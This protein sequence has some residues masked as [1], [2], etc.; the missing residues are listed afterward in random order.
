MK[1]RDEY[2]KR[3]REKH[4]DEINKRKKEHY[5]NNKDKALAYRK[6]N[7]EDISESGAK[8]YKKNRKIILKKG[9]IYREKNKEII[10]KNKS[11]YGK[12]NRCEIR[13][14][15]IEYYKIPENKKKKDKSRKLYLKNPKNRL[16]ANLRIM[17][18]QSLK[19]YT[20]TGKIKS[21]R[22]YDINYRD[23]I[24]HLKPFPKDISKYHV[25]HIRPLCSFNFMNK[26]GSQNLEEIKK[27]FA[28]EN[29]QWLT[30]FENMSKGGKW[31][32]STTT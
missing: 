29:L 12:K 28:P 6:K 19:I 27:A 14:R 25:D 18:W 5:Q 13:R 23:I 21:S 16:V 15:S 31:K 11:I 32:H 3:Y 4:R 22:E 30:A 9:K 8:Y 7:K 17:L 2:D 20:T 1:E 24:E 10:K 26:D